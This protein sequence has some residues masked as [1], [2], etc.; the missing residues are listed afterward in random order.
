MNRNSSQSFARRFCSFQHFGALAVLAIIGVFCLPLY[1]QNI[2]ADV[3]GTVTDPSGA[4][5]PGA[6]VTIQETGTNA[7]RTTQ[8]GDGGDF[9]FTLLPIGTY[10]LSVQAAGFQSYK[11]S[12]ISASAGARLRVDANLHVGA[13]S[14]QT[15][16]VVASGNIVQTDSSSVGGTIPQETVQDIPLNGRNLTNLVTLQ[17]GISTGTS[18]SI[19]NGSRPD[20]RRQSSEVVANGQAE[21][22]NNNVLDGVDNNE[23]FYGLGGIKPSISAVQEVQVQTG[24]FSADLGRAAGAVVS[25][26]TKSGTNSFHGDVFEYFRNDIFDAKEYFTP[27]GAPTQKWR[28]NQFGGSIGGHL[29]KDKDFF[30]GSIEEMR[31]VQGITSP[32]QLVPSADDR[33]FIA[34]LPADQLDP[35]GVHVFNLY[36]K[37]NVPGTNFYV[38]SPSKTQNITTLDARF[39]EHLSTKDQIFGRFNYNPTTSFFPAFFPICGTPENDCNGDTT[40]TGINPVGAGFIANGQFPGTNKTV[41]YGS[42]IDYLHQFSPNLLMELRAGQFRI[43]INSEPISKGSNAGQKLGIPNSN[44][45]EDDPLSTG[46]PGFH[47]ADGYADLGDQIAYPIKNIGNSYQ[48]N[49]DVTYVHGVHS[50]KAGSALVRRQLNY[51]QEFAAEGWFFYIPLVSTPTPVLMAQGVHAIIAPFGPFGPQ[52]PFAPLFVNRQ[53]MRQ[54]EYLRDWETSAYVKDDWRVRQWLTLN[55]GVR[56]DVYTPFNE[57]KNKLSNFDLDTLSFNI[58]GTGKVQTKYGNISPRFGFAAQLGHGLV[59]HGGYGMVY[60]PGDVSNSLILLNLPNNVGVNCNGLFSFQGLC[61]PS[62]GPPTSPAYVDPTV[63]YSADATNAAVGGTVNVVGKSKKY[64]TAYLH[65]YN[66]T[67][68]K[69]FGA[70]AITLGYVGSLGRHQSQINGWDANYTQPDAQGNVPISGWSQGAPQ[71]ARYYAS[72][73]PGVG[74]VQ[75]FDFGGTSNYNA[76]QVIF[77]RRVSEGLRVNANYTWAHGLDNWSGISSSG[78]PAMWRFNYSYDYGNSDIDLAGRIA[79]TATYDVPLGKNLKGAGSVVAKGWKLSSS[80]F[81]QTGLPFTVVTSNKPGGAFGDT[82]YSMRV[83]VVPGQSYYSSSKSIGNWLN[84]SAYVDPL[85]LLTPD[86]STSFTLGNEGSGQLRGPHIRQFDLAAYKNID[87]KDHLKMQFRA[88]CFN[89]SNTP[90]FTNPGNDINSSTFGQ[91]TS[92]NFGMFPRVFQFALKLSY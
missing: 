83:N 6:S 82:N 56:Y 32:Q 73:L 11:V 18:S 55:L 58:G 40:V 41:T 22:F 57:A 12:G 8:T 69:Q 4:V 92:T 21:Y 46:M 49:G 89:L 24:N 9:T 51:L 42:Q 90:N 66:L 19:T 67:L 64:P 14:A 20:D 10:S 84:R 33:A 54:R 47:F 50:L 91:I 16:E 81:W 3:L 5:I 17:A 27:A 88:E 71:T 61:Q 37:P 68:Q 74:Q 38:S 59:M 15:V 44:T 65:Q 76:M 34:S 13:A 39:D 31:L 53:N 25:I 72:E 45:P 1:S 28:Q 75:Y 30:F 48:L 29:R 36:P 79:Y 26:L 77:E 52:F 86:V 62:D 2:T 23:R 43:N 63:I 70:N 78:A 7:V 80:G 60:Y 35:A 85:S 87:L